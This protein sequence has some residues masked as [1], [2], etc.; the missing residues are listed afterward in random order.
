MRVAQVAGEH[1]ASEKPGIT[2]CGIPFDE[3][4]VTD[5]R[6]R[7]PMCRPCGRATKRRGKRRSQFPGTSDYAV[8]LWPDDLLPDLP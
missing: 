7:L 5:Y 2:L 3:P 1:H 6:V 8:S 4:H